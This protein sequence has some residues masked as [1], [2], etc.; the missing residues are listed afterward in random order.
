MIESR[1]PPGVRRE[2]LA[3]EGRVVR[4]GRG[5]L[6]E[7]AAALGAVRRARGLRQADVAALMGTSQSCVSDFERAKTNPQLDFIA[8]YAAAVGARLRV[9]V[10]LS[11]DGAIARERPIRH[12]PFDVQGAEP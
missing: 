9:D 10:A 12:A 2:A 5:L 11:G 3:D 1:Q 8:R 6:A 4:V 7:L